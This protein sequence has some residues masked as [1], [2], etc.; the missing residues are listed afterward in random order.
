[1][2]EPKGVLPAVPV[3]LTWRELNRATLARQLLL[4]RSS[5]SAADAVRRVVALQAQQPASPYV[6]LW[7]RLCC[8]DPAELDAAFAGHR[9]VRAQLMRITMHAVGQAA[10]RRGPAAPRLIPS[11]AADWVLPG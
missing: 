11:A 6:A 1:V 8:F 3:S 7:N 9:V 2:S 10:R 4:D 5:L